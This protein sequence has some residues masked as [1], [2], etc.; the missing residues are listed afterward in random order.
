MARQQ[1]FKDRC[2]SQKGTG[3]EMARKFKPDAVML[4]IAYQL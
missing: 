4:D 1:G 3:L 2:P